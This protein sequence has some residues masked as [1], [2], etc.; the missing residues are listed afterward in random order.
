MKKSVT[1]S[2]NGKY[3]QHMIKMAEDLY[4][5]KKMDLRGLL[6]L[7]WGYIHVYEYY[8]PTTSPRMAW[9]DKAYFVW[10]R[11]LGGGTKT[12]INGPGPKTKMATM[13][14]YGKTLQKTSN[15]EPKCLLTLTPGM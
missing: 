8:F 2:V 3:L 10:D 9:P 1:W 14:I 13:H 5:W 11:S 15:P 7:P 6:H 12:Y 4:L